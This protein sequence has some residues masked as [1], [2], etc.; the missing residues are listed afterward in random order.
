MNQL[1]NQQ[2]V[3]LAILVSFVTSIAT[4]IFTVSLLDQAPPTVTSTL[5]K[6][7]ERTVEV[8]TPTEKETVIREKIVV[9]RNGE[10]VVS[11]IENTADALVE[12]GLKREDETSTSTPLF[13][14]I[15]SGFFI[16]QDGT[17]LTLAH[18]L[19]K[20]KILH[21]RTIDG[22]LIE[23]SLVT[24]SDAQ[25]L[26]LLV[27]TQKM[28]VTHLTVAKNA[29]ATG[30]TAI[31]LDQKEVAVTFISQILNGSATDSS[32]KLYFEN[33]GAVAGRPVINVEGNVIGILSEGKTVIPVET[34]S[35]FL[36]DT[37][38]EESSTSTDSE[39]TGDEAGV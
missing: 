38:S 33:N 22:E 30:Q 25:N 2:V 20:D 37:Q 1:N 5:N 12:I 15:N 18:G 4:G 27:P 13:T 32:Y 26:A 7:V 36:E 23:L 16:K 6:V 29:I 14:K 31:V 39:S 21:G 9:D 17:I 8:V 3:L 11:A 34:I 28:N 19:P 10:A 35:T 24:R